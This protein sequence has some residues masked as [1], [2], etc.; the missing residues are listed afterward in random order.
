MSAQQTYLSHHTATPSRHIIISTRSRAV[1]SSTAHKH[2]TLSSQNPMHGW[3]SM[4]MRK[5]PQHKCQT[6]PASPH[7]WTL[8]TTFKF[9]RHRNDCKMYASIHRH[10]QLWPPLL[11][12]L[13]RRQRMRHPP[14]M[15]YSRKHSTQSMRIHSN[16]CSTEI[17]MISIIWFDFVLGVLGVG[18]VCV[19]REFGQQPDGRTIYYILLQCKTHNTIMNKAFVIEFPVS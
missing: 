6:R 11:L 18:W 17:S 13:S 5:P 4:M 3:A 2:W 9:P 12:L 10:R 16:S 15:I 8:S 7:S 19:C 1:S 14:A